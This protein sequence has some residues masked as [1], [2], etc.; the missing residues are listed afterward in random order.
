[1]H[2]DD[3]N[4]SLG[5]QDARGRNRVRLAREHAPGLRT[6]TLSLLTL[7]VPG[8]RADDFCV[9]CL[10]GFARS[11]VWEAAH[12]VCRRRVPPRDTLRV[13][14][15]S[16]ADRLSRGVAR[17][18]TLPGSSRWFSFWGRVPSFFDLKKIAPRVRFC[19]KI[20]LSKEAADRT[21]HAPRRGARGSRT[22]PGRALIPTRSQWRP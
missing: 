12:K 5:A 18:V 6:G 16:D 7:I 1:M 13:R 9:R 4:R 22:R 19:G 11:R 15:R 2:R 14:V 8:V 20:A 3:P 21:V 17:A 10:F